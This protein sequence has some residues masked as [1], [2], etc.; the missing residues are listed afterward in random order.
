LVHEILHFLGRAICHQLE[1]RSLLISGETLS[2]CAR[3]T[4]IYIGI[5]STLSYLQT[6]KRNKAITI[7]TLRCSFFLLLL[8]LPMMIDGLGSYTHMFETNNLRRLVSGIS[9]GLVLPYFLYPL[10]SK[11]SLEQMSQPVI[12]Q[13]RDFLFPLLLSI[14]LGG[15]FYWGQPS[16]LIL[17]SL[18]VVTIIIWFSLL[19]SFLFSFIQRISIKWGLSLFTSI[20]FLSLLSVLHSWVLSF[21]GN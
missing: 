3:D 10:L 9:F 13:S 17:D 14:T 8:L 7:P 1:E 6:F 16:Y 15:L 21:P 11:K 12:T 18:L 5:F 19:S 20:A 4:G 2:V